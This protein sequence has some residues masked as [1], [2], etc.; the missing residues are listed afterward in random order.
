[1]NDKPVP[2]A[3]ILIASFNTR[4]LL[5]ECIQTLQRE[6]A[7]VSYELI[8]ID[9]A[10]HDGSADMVAAEFPEARLIRSEINLG[11]AAANNRGFEVA[12]G[13]YIVLLNSDAFLRPGALRLSIDHMD[14]HPDAGLAGGRLVGRDD[15]WQPS[16]RMFPSALNAMLAMSGLAA[17]Y[18][19]SRFFGRADRTWADPFHPARLTGYPAPILLSGA[20]YL[21]ASDSST[22]V[23]F[24]I[25]KKWTCAGGS[26]RQK[27]KSGTGLISPLCISAVNRP[28]S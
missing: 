13:R 5:R 16:A 3:S 20:P 14:A 26:R 19:K 28:K 18:P 1:M 25:T 21:I 11:F 8:V 23:S 27:M 15:S 10:S 4:D 2:E 9:N 7:G 22:S 6:S 17:K 24:S 12:R